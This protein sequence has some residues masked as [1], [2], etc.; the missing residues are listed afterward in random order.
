MLSAVRTSKNLCVR[1]RA[2]EGPIR[3]PVNLALLVDT[4]DSMASGRLDAV[5]KTL[6]AARS[7]LRDTDTITLITFGTEATIIIST[8]QLDAIGMDHFYEAV[9]AIQTNGMTNMSAGLEALASTKATYDA[10]V[11]LTDG[12]V[13]QGIMTTEGLRSMAL[14]VTGQ[15][16]IHTLGYG[17]DHNRELLRDLAMRSR[18]TYTYVSSDE[19]LPLVMGDVIEGLR[20]QVL[21][22]AELTVPSGWVCQEFDGD[23]NR[24][25]VGDVVP[26]R[27][28]WVVFACS[29]PQ[30]GM[31][32]LTAKEGGWEL[33]RV[34][35]SDC[36]DLREQVMRCRVAQAIVATTNLMERGVDTHIA[37]KALLREF[38]E[39]TDTEKQRPLMLRMRAQLEEIIDVDI[40]NESM[41]RISAGGA[42][43]ATQRGGGF[44]SPAQLDTS[45]RLSIEYSAV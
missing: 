6:V 13:N 9:A 4:S 20:S 43:L 7:L 2:S 24:Y 40:S 42:N 26:D 39:M 36:Q 34:P 23:G 18:G 10:L 21:T 19:M 27:D 44:S 11:I 22:G 17:A 16:P 41:A 15:L 3:H 5:K 25:R 38:D 45:T 8:L 28:Y 12:C 1:I 37:V 35:I 30:D 14:S 31:I 33:E 32:F 29:E